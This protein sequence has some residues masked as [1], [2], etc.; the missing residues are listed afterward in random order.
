M[1]ATSTDALYL[2]DKPTGRSSFDVVR[3]AT[4][5][6]GTRRVGHTG[7][8]D[9]F[10][11]GLLIVLAGAGTRLIPYVPDEPKVYRA[12]I[13]FG[14][15]TTTDDPT[16]AV[17]ATAPAPLPAQVA[18]VLPRLTGNIQQI[19]PAYSAKKVGGTRAYHLARCGHEPTLRAAEV[20]VDSWEVLGWDAA[21]L[22]VRVS[23]GRGT[24][25]RALARDLGRLV[26]SAAHCSALRRERC[27]DFDV[28][29][30]T[31][32][33][34]LQRGELEP[35]PLA[36][37]LGAIERV[38]LPEDQAA[39]A[40]HGMRI[41]ATS[42]AARVALFFPDGRLLGLARR[43]GDTWHPHLVIPHA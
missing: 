7:T 20:R 17:T 16:G 30:A 36:D 8:L 37:A 5:V 32:W 31:S 26:E 14:H 13:A 39:R 28:A 6:L 18:A 4:R 10:A 15:E 21:T 9:P 42:G 3:A 12:T 19:P 33:E 23:C 29:D 1:I 43:D 35:R 22:H 41:P 11:S 25:I 38:A 27:G 34:D 2:F 40:R 24:Y